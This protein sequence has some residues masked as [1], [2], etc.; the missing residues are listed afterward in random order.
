MLETENV[1]PDEE[2]T[3]ED[4]TP[5]APDES[6]LK[7][8]N[9][10]SPDT[11]MSKEDTMPGSTPDEKPPIPTN[12]SPKSRTPRSP[13]QIRQM[14]ERG[15]AFERAM[16]GSLNKVRKGNYYET[17]DLKEF[18]EM[19]DEEFKEFSSRKYPLKPSNE[20]SGGN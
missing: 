20:S 10:S 3:T 12:K 1:S 6:R 19:S 17:V 9:E 4:E 7:P 11:P 14:Q 15:E 5:S 8:S 16:L 2:S 13:E 18:L